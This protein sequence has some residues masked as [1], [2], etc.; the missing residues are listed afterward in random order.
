MDVLVV[1]AR[2]R[3]VVEAQHRVHA[4]AVADGSVV[5]SCGDPALLTLFRSSAKPI[6]ALPLVR[7]RPD[8]D[9][10]EIAIACAS[11]RH[12]PDQLELV[13]SLLDRSG[14]S[15]DDLE[16]GDGPAAIEH[17]CSGKHA[18]FVLL[19]HERGWPRTG[20]RLEGH[21][22][23]LEVTVEMASAAEVAPESMPAAV[24]GCGV[25]THALTLTVT[26][27][28]KVAPVFESGGG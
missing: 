2:R 8:L 15:E 5:A 22:C 4:V 6:Q 3:D 27:T 24:D 23:Q 11:H 17:T 25:V 26:F 9:D 21:P 19:C 12:R 28:P 10:A 13:R 16:C 7:A 14:A 20:Y 1:E 18:A